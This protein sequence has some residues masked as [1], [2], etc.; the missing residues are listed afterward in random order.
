LV[1]GSNPSRLTPLYAIISP[2]NPKEA[3][4]KIKESISPPPPTP[5]F[6]A[7]AERTAREGHPEGP[8]AGDIQYYGRFGGY[9]MGR[10]VFP[11]EGQPTERSVHIKRDLA[12]GQI[13]LVNE[14]IFPRSS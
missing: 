6:S 7:F 9:E 4:R 10:V 1:V 8:I 3:L 12:S 13:D 14:G 2:M 11:L 5:E